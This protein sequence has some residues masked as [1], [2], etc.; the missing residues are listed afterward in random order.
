M[1]SNSFNQ[2]PAT[3]YLGCF[4]FSSVLSPVDVYK[5]SLRQNSRSSIAKS[6][7]MCIL[8]SDG[9]TKFY[10]R[11]AVQIYIPILF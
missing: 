11:M 4:Q 9:Y 7:M 2:C 6:K 10:S 1:Y 5:A 3:G 8:K